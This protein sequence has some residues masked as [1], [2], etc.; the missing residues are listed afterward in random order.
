MRVKMVIILI[1]HLTC[2]AKIAIVMKYNSNEH[3]YM[4]DADWL[5]ELQQTSRSFIIIYCLWVDDATIQ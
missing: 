2:I 1:L 3:M 5:E 4:A